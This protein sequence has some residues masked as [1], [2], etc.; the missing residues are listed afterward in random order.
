MTKLGGIAQRIPLDRR[1]MRRSHALRP[2]RHK[3]ASCLGAPV[4]APPKTPS[5]ASHVLGLAARRF[6]AHARP[7]ARRSPPNSLKPQQTKTYPRAIPRPYHA[8]RPVRRGR[9]H[10]ASRKWDRMR[11]LRAGRNALLAPGRP[12]APPGGIRT[13]RQEL[14]DGVSLSRP[15]RKRGPGW[16]TPRWSAARRAPFARAPA[17]QGADGCASRR[18]IA[19]AFCGGSIPPDPLVRDARGIRANPAPAKEYGRRSYARDPQ[20]WE[21]VFGILRSRAR[22]GVSKNEGGRR[23]TQRSSA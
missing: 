11:C 5:P 8:H 7:P 21:P 16:K 12:G 20:K 17:S 15:C 9:F 2:N 10:E 1:L 22:R 23:R 6:R 18:S 14:A 3:R 4:H 19:L 13:P